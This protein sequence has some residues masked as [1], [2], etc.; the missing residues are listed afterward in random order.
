MITKNTSDAE[1]LAPVE[2][3]KFALHQASSK[4]QMDRNDANRF[5]ELV[6]NIAEEEGKLQARWEYRNALAHDASPDAIRRHLTRLITNSPGDEWSGR[7]NDVRRTHNDG[8][9]KEVADILLLL[10]RTTRA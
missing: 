3:A 6:N 4:D 1:L 2:L 10:D 9:R 5:A 7:R 8:L